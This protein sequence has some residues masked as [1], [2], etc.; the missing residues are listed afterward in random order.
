MMNGVLRFVTSPISFLSSKL[1]GTSKSDTAWS[2]K[3]S[4]KTA[5][6]KKKKKNAT[7]SVSSSDSQP[8]AVV[9]PPKKKPATDNA[10]VVNN[11]ERDT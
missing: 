8:K 2:G 11:T 9:R 6:S 5:K 10:S 1:T 4:T 3:Q 7:S